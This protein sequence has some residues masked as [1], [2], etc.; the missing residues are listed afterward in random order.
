MKGRVQQ[1][2][3]ARANS[4]AN[5]AERMVPVSVFYCMS[6]IPCGVRAER[7]CGARGALGPGDVC[8]GFICWPWPRT[9]AG[10]MKDAFLGAGSPASSL[11]CYIG[12]P[13]PKSQK[14]SKYSLFSL[15][16][17]ASRSALPSGLASSSPVVADSQS[18]LL[19]CC[20]CRSFSTVLRPSAQDVLQPF[21][22]VVCFRV[23]RL[24]HVVESVLGNI[25]VVGRVGEQV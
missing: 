18:A 4:R 15:E 10:W 23:S 21:V 2:S 7:R 5:R 16:T 3:Q 19:R 20:S 1:P 8:S 25:P 22:S 6:T 24:F 13:H 17:Q 11:P 12:D 9:R 14:S